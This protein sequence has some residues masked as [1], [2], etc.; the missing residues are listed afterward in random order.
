MIFKNKL[1]I[2][3]DYYFTFITEF[4]VLV[5]GIIVYKCAAINFGNDGFAEYALCR[6]TISFIHPLLLLGFAV[7]IP[8]YIAMFNNPKDRS[9]SDNYFLCGLIISLAFSVIAL[10]LVNLFSG[11]FAFLLFGDK[12]MQAFIFPISL[13]LFGLIVHSICYS[14]FRGMLMMKKA[15]FIQ[16]INLGI[17]PLSIY[18]FKDVV[19]AINITGIVCIAVSAFFLIQITYKMSL[20]TADFNKHGKELFIYGIQRIP[21][22]LALAGFFAFPA[23][24]IAHKSGITIA[25][26]I[27]FSISL[28]NMVG[29]AFGPFSLIM[30][31]KSVQMIRDNDF[32]QLK[33]NTSG[34][35]RFALFSTLSGLVVF[36]IFARQ[37]IYIYLGENFEELIICSR[38]ILLATVGYSIYIC[39]RSVLDAFHYR[40]VNTKNMIICFAAF[41]FIS[42]IIYV[43]ALDYHFL[44][45]AFVLCLSAL[46]LVTYMEYK[47]IFKSPE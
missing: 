40:A 7:G 19:Q 14:Y 43:L 41:L 29:A 46:G 8:R 15:N 32:A 1:K 16:L 26:Y 45:Y 12:N 27:A 22:D 4:I 31:P 2:G 33:K 18:F 37:I 11:S 20:S 35:L 3:R 13:L 21:G 38:I 36:E 47:K 28:L 25:G 42:M 39:L 34:I 30:L 24:I 23:F 6:R 17:I 44:L 10:T 9:V 5:T